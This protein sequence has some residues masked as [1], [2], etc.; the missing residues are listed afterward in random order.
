MRLRSNIISVVYADRDLLEVDG[1]I[2]AEGYGWSES[3]TTSAEDLLDSEFPELVSH[4]N[5]RGEMQLPICVDF[6]SEIAAFT[7]A[8]E[9]RAHA[10][11]NQTGKLTI[12]VGSSLNEWQAGV[13]SLNAEFRYIGS[14]ESSRVRLTLTY[15]FILGG[16]S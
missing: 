8:M 12:A 1:Y 14:N 15:S 10:R 2:A 13:N 9:A 7:Y 6:K 4:Q 11:A 16:S 5:A 3:Y